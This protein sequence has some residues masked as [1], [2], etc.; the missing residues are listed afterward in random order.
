MEWR[1]RWA[2]IYRLVVVLQSSSSFVV[3]LRPSVGDRG[4]LPGLKKEEWRNK[5]R[6][7]LVPP[8]K[9]PRTK[10]EDEDD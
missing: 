8:E 7:S 2:R 1:F 9:R 10:D 5:R 6:V 3:V 4:G